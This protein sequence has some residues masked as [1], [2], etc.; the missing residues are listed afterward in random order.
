MNNECYICDAPLHA[1]MITPVLQ[2]PDDSLR[3]ICEKCA[4]REC[5]DWRDEEEEYDA[6]NN[7]KS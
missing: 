2:L 4:D 6:R 7:F 1:F 5:P 3:Q